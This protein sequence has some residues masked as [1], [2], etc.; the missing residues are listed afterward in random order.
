M[1][2]MAAEWSCVECV[3]AATP[4]TCPL[5]LLR[6]SWLRANSSLGRPS[7]FDGATHPSTLFGLVNIVLINTLLLSLTIPQRLRPRHAL[8]FIL[9]FL[10][11][12]F[13]DQRSSLLLLSI[14]LESLVFPVVKVN[15]FWLRNYFDIVYRAVWLGWFTLCWKIRRVLE[16]LFHLHTLVGRMSFLA[17]WGTS[18]TMDTLFAACLIVS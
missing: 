13:P 17:H 11:N 3:H 9:K 10:L 1:R 8:I 6:F 16:L 12:T 4:L 2:R 7:T 15:V 14:T 5:A 18:F